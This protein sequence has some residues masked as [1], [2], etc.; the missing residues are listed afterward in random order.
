MDHTPA[1]HAGLVYALHMNPRD[2][3]LESHKDY[4][5]KGT[6]SDN[7]LSWTIDTFQPAGKTLEVGCGDGA[8][9][10]LLA[11]RGLD[12]TGVDA[13][14]TGIDR[15]HLYG[16]SAQCLDVS[17]DGL[18]FPDES[19]DTIISL[20][21]FEHLMNPYFVVTEIH[22]V[23]RP[24]ARLICS[25]PNPLTGHPYIYPGLFGYHFFRQF[26]TQAGFAI[27]RVRPWEYA[28]RETI[29]PSWMR[30][31][32]LRS[33]FVAGG[34]RKIIEKTW[35]GFPYFCYWLWTFDCRKT[36]AEDPYQ[37]TVA[38]TQPKG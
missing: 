5:S 25:I 12:A 21:T 18:P 3:A 1:L 23:L 30:V 9:L 37:Q 17:S 14:K 26:L 32:G 34:I 16:L 4:Y 8:L 15:C 11:E 28:P 10:R 38:V 13:S 29:L 2:I 6:Y 19:F 22:R 27:E 36:V 20:E 31:P 7:R 24:D 33:R 35:F